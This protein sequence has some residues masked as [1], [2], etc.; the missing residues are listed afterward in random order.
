MKAA[1]YNNK[2][3]AAYLEKTQEGE[4]LFE[5]D[6]A[7]LKDPESTAISLTLPKSAKPYQSKVL[8]PFFFGL[9]SEGVNKLTQCKLLKIDEEDHFSL[10]LKT[11]ARDTIGAIT[12]KEISE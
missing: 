7:Y 2:V 3:L 5:Y 9:L 1:V 6:Q 11:A 12:V 10:L 4:Y 8:F